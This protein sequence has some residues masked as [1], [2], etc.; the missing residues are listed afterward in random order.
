MWSCCVKYY[1]TQ[2]WCGFSLGAKKERKK[3]KR[4]TKTGSSGGVQGHF[5]FF[6]FGRY[7]HT[8]GK[9]SQ[10][11]AGRSLLVFLFHLISRL[12]LLFFFCSTSHLF[13]LSLLWILWQLAWLGGMAQSGDVC[14]EAVFEQ[15]S[16]VSLAVQ[17]SNKTVPVDHKAWTK[18]E[19]NEPHVWLVYQSVYAKTFCNIGALDLH[20]YKC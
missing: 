6:F 16:S 10:S 14:R 8:A 15:D 19:H 11:P 17:F 9:Q 20:L 3:S 18:P 5:F 13:S 4:Q 12:C 7:F 2:C 1:R